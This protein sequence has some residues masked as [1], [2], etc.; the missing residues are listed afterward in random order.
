MSSH[1][2][3]LNVRQLMAFV[4]LVQQDGLPEDLESLLS[5][6]EFLEKWRAVEVDLQASVR[7]YPDEEEEK[8]YLTA[9]LEAVHGLDPYS[10]GTLALKAR[11]LPLI[12]KLLNSN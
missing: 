8:H 10:A 5:N 6:P 2:E 7:H 1:L 12:Q 9:T 3:N 4:F 11:Y